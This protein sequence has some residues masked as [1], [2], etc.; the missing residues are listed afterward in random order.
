MSEEQKNPESYGLRENKIPNPI[1]IS[2]FGEILTSTLDSRGGL[3]NI[4]EFRG[5]KLINISG[6]NRKVLFFEE[7][8]GN[9]YCYLRKRKCSHS[10][11]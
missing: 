9:F 6:G 1:L 2:S 3:E 5:S 11:S 10:S 7:V 4:D 8:D